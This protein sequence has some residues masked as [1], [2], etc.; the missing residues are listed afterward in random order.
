MAFVLGRSEVLT[1]MNTKGTVFWDVAPYNF[2]E[3][4]VTHHHQNP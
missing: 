2:I 4:S 3:R 1:L